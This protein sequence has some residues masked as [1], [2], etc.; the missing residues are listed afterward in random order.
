LIADS[1]RSAPSIASRR[2]SRGRIAE[3]FLDAPKESL[4][5]ELAQDSA[6]VASLALQSGCPLTTLYHTRSLAAAQG[7]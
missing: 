7:R 2:Q 6:I 4:L 5:G 1:F 3:I